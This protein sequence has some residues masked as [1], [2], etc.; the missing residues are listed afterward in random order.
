MKRNV[1]THRL[2]DGYEDLRYGTEKKKIEIG[3]LV[4]NYM[5]EFHKIGS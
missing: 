4:F 3:Y 5:Q 1:Q 2:Y